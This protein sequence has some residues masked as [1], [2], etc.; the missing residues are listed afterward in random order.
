MSRDRA[1]YFEDFSSS[2]SRG[3]AVKRI[4]TEKGLRCCAV[5]YSLLRIIE[6][7]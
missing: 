2:Q 7:P 1:E 6:N 3:R 4:K 5:K